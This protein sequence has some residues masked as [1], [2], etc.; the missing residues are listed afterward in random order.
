MPKQPKVKRQKKIKAWAVID[1]YGDLQ[2]ADY[3]TD[4]QCPAQENTDAL[5]VYEDKTDAE[6][7]RKTAFDKNDL[8]IVRCTLTL[9]N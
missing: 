2:Y 9:T 1:R 3:I 6:N 5:A 7:H 8:K 4:S